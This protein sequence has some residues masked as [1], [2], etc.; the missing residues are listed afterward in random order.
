VRVGY[1]GPA[2]ELTY[3][4]QA[5]KPVGD[6]GDQYTGY[7]RFGRTI[8][9]RW[10]KATAGN[11]QLEHLLYGFDRDS[12]RTW[13]KRLL[14]EG[15]DFDYSYDGLSQVTQSSLGNLNLNHTAISG[16]PLQQESWDYDSTGNWHGYQIHS[17]GVAALDQQ[18]VHDKGN[19]MTQI[20]DTPYPVLLDRLG[21]WRQVAPDAG[22][23]WNESLKIK[24]DAW[25]RIT[26]IRRVSDD[27]VLGSY[28]YD[29][30]ARRTT[31]TVGGVVWHC[32]YSSQW[33]PLEERKD[34]ETTAALQYYWGARHRDDLV[35]RDRATTGVA[36]TE[37]RYVLMEYYS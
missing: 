25:S 16:I 3:K 20:S 26:E 9:M 32:Y 23:D 27:A 29:A 36:L 22:G 7:D 5:S 30:T 8:D 31:R 28:A 15:E 19:R 34:S 17:S 10:Q 6:A 18:R 12:R 4:K 13:R 14:T 35:R 1:S 2:V 24:W 21:R 33:R 37:I 11:A